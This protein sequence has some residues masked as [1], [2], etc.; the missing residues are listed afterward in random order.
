MCNSMI[1]IFQ[2]TFHGLTA[3]MLA[4]LCREPYLLLPLL[5]LLTV[6]AL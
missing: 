4:E 6:W 2:H 5:L 3:N 1:F